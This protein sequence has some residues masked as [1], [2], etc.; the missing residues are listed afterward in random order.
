MAAEL[1]EHEPMVAKVGRVIRRQKREVA[2]SAFQFLYIEILQHLTVYHNGDRKIIHQKMEDMGLHIGSRLAERYTG[3]LLRMT[4]QLD[5]IK[6][7]C[8]EF[9]IEIFHKQADKLQTNYLGIYVLHDYKFSW[10]TRLSHT[11]AELQEAQ[12]VVSFASGIIRGALKNLGM[13]AKVTCDIV[14]IPRCTF[15]IQ[16]SSTLPSGKSAKKS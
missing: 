3:Q 2:E 12:A 6:F 1:K 7:V 15:T 16:D 14:Q 10:L 11:Q 8:K 5:I 13:H 4:E 9:W